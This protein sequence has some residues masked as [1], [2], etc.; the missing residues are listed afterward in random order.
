MKAPAQPAQPAQPIKV[1]VADDNALFREGLAHMLASDPRVEVVGQARDGEDAV[2]QALALRP[3]AVLMSVDMPRLNGVD[4]TRRLAQDAPEVYVLALTAS[5]DNV[6]VGDALANGARQ[7]FT[8]DATMRDVMASLLTVA[9]T[10]SVSAKSSLSRLSSRELHVLRQ[11][12]IGLSNKQVARRLGISERTV[13]NHLTMIF[14]KLGVMTRT[15]AVV[16]AIRSGHIAV[17]ITEPAI[18]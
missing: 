12:A 3:H 5:G 16:T 14:R 11:V 8:K 13:R 2:R 7:F 9:A 10:A 1:L 6:D 18:D 17:G 4:A 15:E